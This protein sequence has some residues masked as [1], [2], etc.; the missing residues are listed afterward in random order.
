MVSATD[1][2]PLTSWCRKAGY[3]QRSRTYY[4]AEGFQGLLAGAAVAAEDRN[5]RSITE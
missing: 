5:R 1:C 4:Q 3:T 2:L